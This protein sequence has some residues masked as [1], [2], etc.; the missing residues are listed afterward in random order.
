M[1]NRYAGDV[2]DFGKL[3]LLRQIA[4]TGFNIGVNWYLAPD[5]VHNDDGKHV[6][7]LTDWRYAGCDD[8]LRSSLYHLV[9]SE[10]SVS[11]I[12]KQN[13]IPHAAYYNELL[14]SPA[15]AFSRQKWHANA[16][17]TLK[18]SNV[19]FLDPDNGVLVKSVSFRSKKSNKYLLPSEITDYYAAGKSVI[20][21]NHRCRQKE[22]AYLQRFEWMH[23]D[24]KLKSAYF[25]GLKFVRGTIRDYLFILQPNHM[26]RILERV[27]KMLQS[28][29]GK[30]FIKLDLS[31]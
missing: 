26:L 16:L 8:S 4:S 5:E 1:Q 17:N 22:A 18:N 29:W 2:G 28:P 30:H 11:A 12:E 10:R 6:G 15:E 31:V 25:T 23:E 27:D 3:G 19:V 13:L 14:L 7:Y 24:P 9:N 20:F 21:Y